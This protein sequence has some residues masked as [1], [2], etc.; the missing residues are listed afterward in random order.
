MCVCISDCLLLQISTNA[1]YNRSF[2]FTLQ[3]G[4]EF[5]E[6]TAELFRDGGMEV[7]ECH[8]MRWKDYWICLIRL[9]TRQR[10]DVVMDFI[11]S[12]C[13]GEGDIE[14]DAKGFSRPLVNDKSND[15]HQD[16]RFLSMM[17]CLR[18]R[19]SSNFSTWTE[20]GEGGLLDNYIE[21]FPNSDDEEEVS[22]HFCSYA[23]RV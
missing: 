5:S 22:K 1:K 23:N 16:S 2:I 14:V 12:I 20:N 17:R 19:I 13:D 18:S 21:K 6:P 15:M 4:A 8:S 11:L 9:K 3:Y 10:A 7:S